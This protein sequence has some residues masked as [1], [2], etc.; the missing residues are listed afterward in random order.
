[1]SISR[2]RAR[3]AQLRCWA[4]QDTEGGGAWPALHVP[5]SSQREWEGERGSR[6]S[7]CCGAWSQRSCHC[8]T[9]REAGKPAGLCT[10]ALRLHRIQLGQGLRTCP[11]LRCVLQVAVNHTQTHW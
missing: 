4:V 3:R 10:C 7:E 11:G 1:M 6:L 9:H 5:G 2:R 8:E